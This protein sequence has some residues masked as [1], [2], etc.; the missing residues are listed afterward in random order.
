MC[1]CVKHSIPLLLYTQDYY[2]YKFHKTPK[3][4]RNRTDSDGKAVV[5]S[6]GAFVSVC[7]CV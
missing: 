4:V 3:F 1:V 2:N 7:V 5:N 6:Y